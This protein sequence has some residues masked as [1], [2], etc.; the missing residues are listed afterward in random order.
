M[1]V[2]ISLIA[3]LLVIVVLY[4]LNKCPVRR[5]PSEVAELLHARLAGE[6]DDGQWDY[7]T[8][9]KIWDVQLEE[10]WQLVEASEVLGSPCLAPTGG[11]MLRLSK[12][13]RAHYET[14]ENVVYR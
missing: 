4:Y 1:M 11:D 8:S 6:K 2:W 14:C 10:I 5:T 3:M 12:A 13:G 9:C 7:F